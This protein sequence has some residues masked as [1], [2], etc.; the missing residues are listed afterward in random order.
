MTCKTRNK[1]GNKTYRR[2]LKKCSNAIRTC[3]SSL[4][5]TFLLVCVLV[6]GEEVL[7]SP[8]LEKCWAKN[9]F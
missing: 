5:L 7:L 2:Y 1:P 8:N 9:E 6:H 4:S 3:T